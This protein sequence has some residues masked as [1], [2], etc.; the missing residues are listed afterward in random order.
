MP[1]GKGG[2]W[3]SS[4]AGEITRLL[5]RWRG[6]DPTAFD[7]LHPLIRVELHRIAQRHLAREGKAH[8]VQLSSLVQETFL[9]LLPERNA[10]WQNRAHFFAV[11]STVMRHV[12]VD[13][14]RQRRR[15]KRGAGAERVPLDA[16]AVLSP[17]QV[18]EV[19]AIDL[20]LRR[21][22]EVDRRKSQVFEMR[23]FGGLG[24]DE[25]AEV[26]GVGART[27]MRDWRFARAWL[28][29]ELSSAR[30]IDDPSGD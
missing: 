19:V 13:Y 27:V 5:E 17:E 11:A 20:A 12:L 24:V 28:R 2:G 3:V 22:A 8:G 21:L 10:S 6:G 9:R 18:D 14:A 23:F 25:T 29:R 16:V 1:D 30:A 26:L 7:A 4:T 15:I